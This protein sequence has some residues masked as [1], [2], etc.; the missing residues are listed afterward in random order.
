MQLICTYVNIRRDSAPSLNLPG[1]LCQIVGLALDSVRYP[2]KKLR[3][4]AGEIYPLAYA[5][6]CQ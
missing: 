1:Y 3:K 6:S 4:K 2:F 5:I